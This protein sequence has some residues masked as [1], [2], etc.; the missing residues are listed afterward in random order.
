M[1]FN[2]LLNITLLWKEIWIVEICRIEVRIG[3]LISIRSNIIEF[4]NNSSERE[5]I[6]TEATASFLQVFFIESIQFS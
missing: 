4:N 3:S 1:T 2:H 6:K 5:K